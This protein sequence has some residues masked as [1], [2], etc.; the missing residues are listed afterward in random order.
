MRSSTYDNMD[1]VPCIDS[2]KKRNPFA[3]A[4]WVL[5]HCIASI[6]VGCR[7]KQGTPIKNMHIYS[8]QMDKL[9]CRGDI[10]KNHDTKNDDVVNV[11]M[12][13]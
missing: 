3:C 8:R 12:S 10:A 4:Q 2:T 13:I 1:F 7:I 6:L 11:A 5:L 9:C